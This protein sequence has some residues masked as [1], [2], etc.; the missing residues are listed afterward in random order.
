[1]SIFLIAKILWALTGLYWLVS[2]INV[3]K[4]LEREESLCRLFY[5]CFW[6]VGVLLIFTND[7]PFPFLYKPLFPQNSM[8]QAIGLI[9]TLAGLAFAIW[10]R[11][12][13]GNNWSGRVTLKEGHELITHGPYAISRNPIYSGFLLGLCGAAFIEG[14][15]KDLLGLVLLVIG[16]HLKIYREERLM[17]QNFGARYLAYMAKVSRLIPFIY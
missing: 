12:S 1:M 5:L 14:L 3:K 17:K 11:A 10:G 16:M 6:L 4:T 13:L 8:M 9:C 2:A 15:L 7:F